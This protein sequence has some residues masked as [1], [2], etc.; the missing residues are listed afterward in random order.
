MSLGKL[1]KRRRIQ[2]LLTQEEL[3]TRLN[4]SKS[5]I[6]KWETDGGIPDRDNLY[7]LAEVLKISV[8]DLHQIIS[9]EKNKNKDFELNI[10][11][12]VINLLEMHGYKVV[13]RDGKEEKLRE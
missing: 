7:K 3:A 10:T 1:I 11:Q 9:G 8:D 2:L 4:V 5:A 6:G 12:D 13:K